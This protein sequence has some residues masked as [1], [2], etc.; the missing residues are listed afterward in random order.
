MSL[1][2]NEI[3]YPVICM[4]SHKNYLY[5]YFY[6]IEL[7]YKWNDNKVIGT[8]LL[9]FKNWCTYNLVEKKKH[10]ADLRNVLTV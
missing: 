8:Y 5:L 10:L 3:D 4:L 2:T 9:Y 6:N 7:N 1:I